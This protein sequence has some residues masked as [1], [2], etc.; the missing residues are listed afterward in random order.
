MKYQMARQ[1]WNQAPQMMMTPDEIKDLVPII[2]IDKANV[3]YFILFFIFW[4]I[5]ANPVIRVTPVLG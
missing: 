3:T 2:D 4:Q 1:G 5:N